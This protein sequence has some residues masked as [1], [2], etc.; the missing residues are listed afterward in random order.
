MNEIELRKSMTITEALAEIKTIGKRVETKRD[1]VRQHLT[2]HE[3]FRDPLEAEGGQPDAIKTARQSLGDLLERIVKLRVAI[4][5]ANASETVTVEGVTKTVQ[6][7]LVW[8]R[9]VAPQLADAFTKW[10]QKI[11]ADRQQAVS[12]GMGVRESGASESKTAVNDL[13]VN[14]SEKDFAD[15][16]EK[17]QNILGVLDGQLQLFN[18]TAKVELS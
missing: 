17:M 9:E 8:R 10:M 12:R 11:Q 3:A 15:E 7:W 2:R 4:S 6:E 16:I 18:A 13:L 1:F 5:R 14:I